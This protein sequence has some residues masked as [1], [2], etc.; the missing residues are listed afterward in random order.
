MFR[1]RYQMELIVCS[2]IMALAIALHMTERVHA[3][4]SH[5]SH[6][7]RESCY[8]IVDGTCDAYHF[9]SYNEEYQVRNCTV[10]GTGTKHK[11]SATT[12]TCKAQLESW[13]PDGKCTCTVCGTT[14]PWSSAPAKSHTF[15][16]QKVVCE[17]EEGE[18][19]ATLSVSADTAWTNKGV[20]ISAHVNVLKEDDSSRG[21]TLNWPDGKMVAE[22]NGTYTVT[23]TNSLGQSIS[24]SATIACI[25]KVAPVIGSVTGNTDTMTKSEI[26][27]SFSA[28]D[29][30]SGL[31][32]S[33]YSLDGGSTWSGN[34][35]FTLKEGAPVTITVRDKAGNTTSKTVKRGDFPYPKEPEKTAPGGSTSGGSSGGGSTS[36]GGS[37][38]SGSGSSDSGGGSDTTATEN[39]S[40]SESGT[41]GAGSKTGNTSK[42]S[43]KKKENTKEED[44][45]SADGQ[46]GASGEEDLEK[47]KKGFLLPN[48][49]SYPWNNRINS[50]PLAG[51]AETEEAE[52]TEKATVTDMEI[53]GAEG[54]K[55]DG[56]F[57]ALQVLLSEKL[58]DIVVGT[59]L[60]VAAAIVGILIWS[61]SVEVYC[62]DGGDS[63]RKLG[64]AFVKKSDGN[65]EMSLPENMTDSKNIPRYR[66]ILKKNFAKHCK[67]MSL[68]ILAGD[69]KL[70]QSMEECM[71]FAL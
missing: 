52:A 34:N 45:N 63:Y 27:I 68:T 12:I 43:E 28:S 44:K 60:L 4:E 29:G 9:S 24:A 37:S 31:A 16:V 39:G 13:Q 40:G 50:I 35:T 56:I 69:R 59:V 1:K 8:K 6:S 71:D 22:E 5:F 48:F 62:Y 42:D 23:A 51:E 7:H 25:D 17:M 30:E 70:Q 67:G 26:T 20:T 38:S 41:G 66:L 58:T 10:C 61:H 15:Q 2:L 57:T 14:T 33:P 46:N 49:G 64:V 18:T 21:I 55:E 65:Y 53:S 54:S 3:A 32:E 47:D 36:G 19:T 11:L